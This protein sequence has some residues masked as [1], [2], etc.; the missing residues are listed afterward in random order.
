M[1]LKFSQAADLLA[2]LAALDGYDRIIKDAGNERIA[3]ELY[4]LGP[5]RLPIAK[6]IRVLRE[7]LEDFQRARNGLVME[8]SGG[9]GELDPKADP[10]GAAQ[11]GLAVQTLLDTEQ[12]LALEPLPEAE[13]LAAGPVPPS[14][15]ASLI[16][17]L[18]PPPQD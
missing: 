8:A 2:A 1:K 18:P 13:L 12:E 9:K 17:L 7:A 14:V 10:A 3:R 11:L 5:L 6:N 16:V 15:L 4:K